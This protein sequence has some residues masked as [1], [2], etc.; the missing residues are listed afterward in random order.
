MYSATSTLREASQRHCLFQPGISYCPIT[1][2]PFHLWQTVFCDFIVFVDIQ[3]LSL[4]PCFRVGETNVSSTVC[5]CSGSSTVLTSVTST[6]V[7]STSVTSESVTSTSATS[8]SVM[9]LLA[10]VTPTALLPT[11]LKLPDECKS[12]SEFYVFIGVTA[13]LFSLAAIIFYVFAH[14][15]YAGF[16]IIPKAVSFLYRFSYTCL[17]WSFQ[18]VLNSN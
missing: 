11:E 1:N 3:S 14:E 13:F 8:T 10:S 6:S 9:A 2:S 17:M 12:S 18:A 16:A 7:A 4:L 5:Q 15:Q